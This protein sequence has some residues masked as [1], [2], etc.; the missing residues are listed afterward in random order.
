MLVTKQ[1]GFSL[2]TIVWTK[3]YNGSQWTPEPFG[4]QHFP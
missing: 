2:A 3:K 1:F 4:Y